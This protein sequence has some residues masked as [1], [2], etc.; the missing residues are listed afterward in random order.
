MKQSAVSKTP[1]DGPY[2]HWKKKMPFWMDAT[3]QE[4][5]PSKNAIKQPKSEDSICLLFKMVDGVLQVLQQ[6]RPTINMESRVLAGRMAKVDRGPIKS[7]TL[8]TRKK[9]YIAD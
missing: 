4:T 1:E 7:I 2:L 9:L 6:P 8:I 3:M 5:K